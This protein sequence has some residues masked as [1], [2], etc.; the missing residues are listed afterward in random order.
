MVTAPIRP[1]ALQRC[2]K[3]KPGASRGRKATDLAAAET[4]GLPTCEEHPFSTLGAL[5]HPVRSAPWRTE[6]RQ[7]PPHAPD[8]RHRR[9]PAPPQAN[10]SRARRR[11]ECRRTGPTGHSS[12]TPSET[13]H[14]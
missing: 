9:C 1:S 14:G 13:A 3:G 10:A 11:R 7:P 12:A 8:V 5:V 6:R 2:E 4:A